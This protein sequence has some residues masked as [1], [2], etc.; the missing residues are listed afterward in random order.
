[1]AISTDSQIEALDFHLLPG[2]TSW[3]INRSN[4]MLAD[5]RGRTSRP[6]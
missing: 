3:D 5:G 6:S 2:V 4:R 1:M